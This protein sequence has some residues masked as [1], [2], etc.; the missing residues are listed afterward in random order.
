M[1]SRSVVVEVW[2][3]SADAC[4]IW[5]VSGGDAWRSAAIPADSEPHFEVELLLAGHDAAS[6]V[7]LHST[8]WRP[9]GPTVVL[10]YI[11]ALVNSGV[12]LSQWPAALPVSADL[13]PVVGKPH[14]HGA[15]EVPL[16]RYIDV[17][18]HALHHLAYLVRTDGT[19]RA[20]LPGY[21]AEHLADLESALAGM[22]EK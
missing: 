8:S 4:G 21:W 14:P 18:H 7:C 12:V 11:A 6:P 10:T 19:V 15:T 16:P 1:E 22:Y 3:I 20:A 5:L 17:L 9:D 2:S 13:L